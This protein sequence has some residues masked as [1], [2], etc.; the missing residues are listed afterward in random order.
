VAQ[1]T[2]LVAVDRLHLRAL[3]PGGGL[4]DEYRPLGLALLAQQLAV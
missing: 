1:E 2:G 3:F 4:P